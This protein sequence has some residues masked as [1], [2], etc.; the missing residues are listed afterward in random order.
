[1]NIKK[2]IY[3]PHITYIYDLLYLFWNLKVNKNEEN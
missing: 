2:I 1:M 3:L